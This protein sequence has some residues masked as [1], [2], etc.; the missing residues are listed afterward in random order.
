MATDNQNVIF[1]FR[2]YLEKISGIPAYIQ[3]N[4]NGANAVPLWDITLE[5][6]MKLDM[7]KSTFMN[8]DII[9]KVTLIV[10]LKNTQQAL[11][12]LFNTLKTINDF[13]K[14]SG[15]MM[16]SEG[17]GDS[18]I[19]KAEIEPET[20]ENNIKLSFPYLLKTIIQN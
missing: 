10:D 9:I 3:Y 1:N 19:T 13:D 7:F 4:D 11:T 12:I 16:G 8:A 6:A 18:Q 2:E 14:A 5:E 15:S 17:E 20:D